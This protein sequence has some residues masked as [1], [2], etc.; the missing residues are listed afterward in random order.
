MPLDR[1]RLAK[2]LGLIGSEHDGEVLTAARMAEK[3]R[4]EANISWDQLLTATPSAAVQNTGQRDVSEEMFTNWQNLKK[5]RAQPK[6]SPPAELIDA[7]AYLTRYGD[8]LTSQERFDVH[9]ASQ[10]IMRG[11]TMPLP[12]R[13]IEQI[14]QTYR[15]VKRYNENFRY[16][17]K[18]E[19]VRVNEEPE[20]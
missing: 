15:K 5:Q 12:D 16:D 4:K 17:G 13:I 1:A 2:I 3:L 18:P 14:L 11:S 10:H 9:Y 19:D 6:W 8:L 20:Y 7:I